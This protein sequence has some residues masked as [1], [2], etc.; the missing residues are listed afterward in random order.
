MRINRGIHLEHLHVCL[1]H[2]KWYLKFKV[3]SSEV[4]L[5]FIRHWIR[6]QLLES[7]LL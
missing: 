4:L 2:V 3:P 5:A 1:S 6:D 7:S